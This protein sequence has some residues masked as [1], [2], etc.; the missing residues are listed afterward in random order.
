MGTSLEFAYFFQLGVLIVL[1]LNF[2]ENFE[3]QAVT[4][5][6]SEASSKRGDFAPVPVL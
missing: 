6:P 2:K 4:L 3:Y 5:I 1:T